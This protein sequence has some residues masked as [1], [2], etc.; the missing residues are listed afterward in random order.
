MGRAELFDPDLVTPMEFIAA[1]WVIGEILLM[2]PESQVNGFVGVV[3]CKGFSYRH[4]KK[5]S[6]TLIKLGIRLAKNVVP[7][8][9]KRLHLINQN[10]FTTVLYKIIKPFLPREYAEMIHFHGDNLEELH[11][12]VPRECLLECF[13]GTIRD[14]QITEEQYRD[15]MLKFDAEYK[16]LNDLGYR[17]NLTSRKT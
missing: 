10:H 8:M 13:G 14:P 12:F 17:T 15:L 11:E 1:F 3:D 5:I 16:A 2:E 7:A 4:S 9:P 6:L